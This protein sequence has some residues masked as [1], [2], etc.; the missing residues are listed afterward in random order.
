MS[1]STKQTKISAPP[2]EPGS[3]P[4]VRYFQ[5]HFEYL[6]EQLQLAS[7]QMVA[8]TEQVQGL[9]AQLARQRETSVPWSKRA[10]V[11]PGAKALER[12]DS[13]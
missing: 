3:F 6:H 1:T 13:N 4:T 7:R 10:E 8:L 9:E 5:V 12:R 11:R 2:P